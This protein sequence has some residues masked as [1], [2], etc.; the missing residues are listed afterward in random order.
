MRRRKT[1]TSP[2]QN[3]TGHMTNTKTRKCRQRNCTTRCPSCGH[4]H[5][6]AFKNFFFCFF[7][8]FPSPLPPQREC[9]KG[10]KPATHQQKAEAKAEAKVVVEVVVEV[11]DAK[12]ADRWKL[13]RA[14]AV[15]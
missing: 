5:T 6:A 14:K 11:T 1:Q 7:H 10:K 9:L 15:K 3:P 12:V 13:G 4:P 8:F 2:P